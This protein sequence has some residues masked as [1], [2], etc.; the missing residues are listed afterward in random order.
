MGAVAAPSARSGVT[1]ASGRV[2]LGNLDGDGG[3]GGC[4]ELAGGWTLGDVDWD[5]DAL[6][7]ELQ[8]MLL[9]HHLTPSDL[10]NSYDADRRGSFSFKDFLVMMKKVPP[11]RG[12][13]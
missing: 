1:L 2:G 10:L 5:E 13:G 7:V 3:D 9:R 12:E 11:A 6:R 4:A 8:L